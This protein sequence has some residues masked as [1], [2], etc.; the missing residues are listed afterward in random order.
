MVMNGGIEIR[1]MGNCE[2]VHMVWRIP[3]DEM[4]DR[5]LRFWVF[6]DFTERNYIKN[7]RGENGLS[8]WLP[9]SRDYF[10]FRFRARNREH[11]L[12]K[13]DRTGILF[14]KWNRAGGH[15]PG[16]SLQTVVKIRSCRAVPDGAPTCH[17]RIPERTSRAEKK[18]FRHGVLR[19]INIHFPPIARTRAPNW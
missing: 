2:A 15:P 14:R 9:R 11:S 12:R 8:G 7:R 17:G 1:L 19:A 6:F 4:S 16:L 13:R 18:L 10:W 3:Q 5:R